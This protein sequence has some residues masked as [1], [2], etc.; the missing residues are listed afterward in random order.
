MYGG[1]SII[2]VEAQ[3]GMLDFGWKK[4]NPVGEDDKSGT[5]I[6][7]GDFGCSKEVATLLFKK[8]HY[9]AKQEADISGIF[10][11]LK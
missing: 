4:A 9:F 5:L 3:I 6:T 8:T 11:S 10:F 1:S 2:T 7:T